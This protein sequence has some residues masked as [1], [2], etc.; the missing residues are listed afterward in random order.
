MER[1]RYIGMMNKMKSF[2]SI[3]YLYRGYPIVVDM[4][5][6]YPMT[7]GIYSQGRYDYIYFDIHTEFPG[8][9]LDK[10]LAETE[11]KINAVIRLKDSLNELAEDVVRR[12]ER[13]SKNHL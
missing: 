3:S 10:A 2:K 12:R 11:I 9:E 1:G 7:I 13:E 5:D 6:G 4:Y 8:D